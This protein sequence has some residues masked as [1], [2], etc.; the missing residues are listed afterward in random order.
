MSRTLIEPKEFPRYIRTFKALG[1]S[2]QAWQPSRGPIDHVLKVG[3]EYLIDTN[4]G[5]F[6][7]INKKSV[8]GKYKSQNQI[9]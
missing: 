6:A 4:R 5:R 2:H 1:K 9:T 7:V 8:I 3:K